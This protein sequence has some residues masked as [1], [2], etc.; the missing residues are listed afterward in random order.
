MGT[1][2][3]NQFTKE[4]IEQIVK[5]SNSLK[6][7]LLKLG[8]KS[9]NGNNNKTLKNYLEKNNIS[10]DHFNGQ[11]ERVKRTEE[12][13]FCKNSTAN[14]STLRKWYIKGNYTEYKCSI[15]GLLPFWNG[16]PLTLTLDHIDGDNHNDELSNL[17]WVC[18]N[19]DRQL[20]T[21][22]FKRGVK[23]I[24]Q[25]SLYFK[26]LQNR[27]IQDS[28]CI[29][30]GKQISRGA[31]RCKDCF[32]KK[33]QT[34]ERPSPEQLKQELCETNFVEVGKKYG[35]TDNTIRKWCKGYGMSSSAKD[36]KKEK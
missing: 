16:Q 29:D 19:C 28:Y 25:D 13:V 7:V 31:I 26:E 14:Q 35:V 4:E 9:T 17:R 1:S 24:R 6:E 33:R 32:N 11:V 22:G 8:Y 3:L 23:N 12:N 10:Y 18:P 30:C 15:C 36:Y 34:V 20:P 27:N 21:F 2:R 5:E